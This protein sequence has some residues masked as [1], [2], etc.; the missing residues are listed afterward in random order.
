[1][2]IAIR[3]AEAYDGELVASIYNEAIT[4]GSYA[5][6]DVE[7]VSAESRVEWIRQR[8]QPYGVFIAEDDRG[9][10]LA[11]S[12]LSPLAIRPAFPNVAEVAV[13]VAGPHR[14]RG[15]CRTLLRYTLIQADEGPFTSIMAA[16]FARNTVSL[17]TITNAG[18]SE[19]GNLRGVTFLRGG[20]ED[21]VLVRRDTS[22]A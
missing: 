10:G 5:T 3:R 8:P 13:Y 18:F 19:C 9:R 22:P 20:W 14:Q 2:D 12:S 6:A 16:I 4:D 17:K 7:P 15:L 1:M 21:V 11:W